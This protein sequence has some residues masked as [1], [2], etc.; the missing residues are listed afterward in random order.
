MWKLCIISLNISDI[1][2]KQIHIVSLI[3][4]YTPDLILLQE[5][6]RCTNTHALQIPSKLGLRHTV[7]SLAVR[8]TGSGTVILQTSDR[9]DILQSSRVNLGRISIV[10]I[11]NSRNMNTIINIHAPTNYNYQAKFYEEL[12]TIDTIF[13]LLVIS[14]VLCQMK[15][16]L[17][18]NSEH[19]WGGPAEKIYTN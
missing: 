14:P 1:N 4:K 13:S 12:D 15:I 19:S 17:G 11:G 7:F 3:H 2:T 8:N 5:T 9:W 18:V 10:E 6:N 16:V